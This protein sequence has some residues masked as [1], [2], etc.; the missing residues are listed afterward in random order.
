M[1]Y[2]LIAMGLL[3][4]AAAILVDRVAVTV[5]DGKRVLLKHDGTWEFMETGKA[6]ERADTVFHFCRTRW[7]MSPQQV[8]AAE[9][10]EPDDRQQSEELLE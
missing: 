10:C 4:L 2:A 3:L 6:S 1:Q 8:I 9:G 7:G 5:A